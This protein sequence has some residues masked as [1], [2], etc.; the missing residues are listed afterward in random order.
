MS[1]KKKSTPAKKESPKTKRISLKDYPRLKTKNNTK[2][3]QDLIDYDYL[4]QLTREE[5]QFLNQ[6]T[7][8]FYCANFAGETIHPKDLQ[9]DCEDRNNS[10]NRDLLTIKQITGG[11]NFVNYG[12]ELDQL[13]EK[14]VDTAISREEF[15]EEIE[16]TEL[17]LSVLKKLSR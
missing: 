1:T 11:V 2:A 5:L 6:F 14:T 3:R 10:R 12:H 13:L 8:E 16:D 7:D 15:L 17:S 9:K 4:K